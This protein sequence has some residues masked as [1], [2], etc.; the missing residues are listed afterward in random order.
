MCFVSVLDDFI[1]VSVKEAKGIDSLETIMGFYIQDRVDLL[2]KRRRKG[3]VLI[4]VFVESIKT[5]SQ[6]SMICHQFNR[7]L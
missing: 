2:R 3:K 5:E 6:Q 4:W 7:L 1:E